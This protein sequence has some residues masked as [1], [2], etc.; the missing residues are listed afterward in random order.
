[1]HLNALA[2]IVLAAFI[3]AG[4]NFLA[5][6]SATGPAFIWCYTLFSILTFAPAAF[7]LIQHGELPQGSTAWIAI[8]ISSL[9]HLGY[10]IALQRGYQ[11]ADLTVVYPVARGTG[12]LFSSL[13]AYLFLGEKATAFSVCGLMIIIGGIGII[14]KLDHLLYKKQN[15][16]LSGLQYGF[17]TG[18]FIASYTLMDAYNVKQL[19]MHPLLFDYL[20]NCIRFALLTP[21]AIINWTETQTLLRKKWKYALGIGA[22]SPFGYFLVLSAI[23]Y[24][25]VSIIAPAREMSMMIAALIGTFYLKEGDGKRRLLGALTIIIGVICLMYK[26]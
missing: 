24:A 1:M 17:I 18:L 11:K 4:W 21:K 23:K 22:V 20:A 14:A 9:F 7:W 12:P 19:A 25:P 26:S 8:F 16:L 5:K 3:H 15:T 6:K 2:L 13:G 10:T